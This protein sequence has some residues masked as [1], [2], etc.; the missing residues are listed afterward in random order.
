MKP[1]FQINHR[2]GLIMLAARTGSCVPENGYNYQA[3]MLD[4]VGDRRIGDCKPPF[5][6]IGQDYFAREAHHHFASEALVFC[7]LMLT[8]ILP[9]LN[10]ASAVLGLIRSIGGAF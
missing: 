8:T 7:L 10:G 9:L 1:I 3:A 6:A 4:D 2:Y 5:R